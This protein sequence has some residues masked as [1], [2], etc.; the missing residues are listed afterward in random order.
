MDC[1]DIPYLHGY[2]ETG[3]LESTKRAIVETYLIC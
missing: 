3:K 1:A 2:V